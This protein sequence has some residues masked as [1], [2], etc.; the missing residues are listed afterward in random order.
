MGRKRQFDTPQILMQIMHIFW[1][2]GYD[3]TTYA[4]L[5]KE[6]GL[7]GRSLINT[8]GDKDQMFSQ[9]LERYYQQTCVSLDKIFIEPGLDAIHGFFDFI[10][11]R[12]AHDPRNRGCLMVNL[13]NSK[14]TLPANIQD[15]VTR[16]FNTFEQHFVK[17]IEAED[18]P[19]ASQKSELLMLLLYGLSTRIRQAQS[20]KA[21]ASVSGEVATLLNSWRT[22]ANV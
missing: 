18:I 16:F 15:I 2:Q 11:S 17:A 9:C 12:P 20:V 6:T 3:A 4:T 13:V 10:V 7:T 1:Q 5:E 19:Q 8:F 21:A 22:M 14:L